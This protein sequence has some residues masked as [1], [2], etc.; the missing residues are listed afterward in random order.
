M[1]EHIADKL[2]PYISS[3]KRFLVLFLE[4]QYVSDLVVLKHFKRYSKSSQI[5]EFILFLLETIQCMF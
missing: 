5:L 3:S 2:P 1:N 4:L